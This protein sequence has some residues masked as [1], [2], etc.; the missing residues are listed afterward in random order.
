MSHSE[1]LQNQAFPCTR[2]L[3]NQLD[4]ASMTILLYLNNTTKPRSKFPGAL[5]NTTL[6]LFSLTTQSLVMSDQTVPSNRSG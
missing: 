5:K 6:S 2:K 3:I 1:I 4:P